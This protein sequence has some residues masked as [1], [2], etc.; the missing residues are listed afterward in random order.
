MIARL[1]LLAGLAG[2]APAAIA[3][4][5][6]EPANARAAKAIDLTGQWVAIVSEDWRW[7]MMTPP[8]NDT[9]S[10][11]VNAEARRVTQAWDLAADNAAGVQCRAWGPGGLIRQP[12]RIRISW[13]DDNTLKLE[14]DSGRQTRLFRFVSATP[15]DVYPA[16]VAATPPSGPRTLQGESRAQ[17]FGYPQTR[18]LGF[19]GP[20]PT[21]SALRVVTRNHSGGYLRKNGVPYSEDAVIT[22]HFNRHD[23]ANGES[24]LTVTT[25]IDDPKYLTRPAVMSTS[26]RKESD[27][28]KWNPQP[29]F[30]A[31]PLEPPVAG[32][33][34]F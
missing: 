19:G 24:W 6:P 16:L 10:L 5:A 9:S 31:P 4:H 13:Q 2:L 32:K 12:M 25:T 33:Q 15:G 20:Q 29:C 22:E 21:G 23:Y 17:W 14:T 28:S 8:K 30:T 11:P 18:G 34:G 3:Q 27:L 26:F 7:R 1:I